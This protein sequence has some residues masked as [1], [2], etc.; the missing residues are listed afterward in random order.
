ML[1]TL[2]KKQ[3]TEIFR[4]YFINRKTGKARSKGGTVGF[5]MFFAM[6]MLFLGLIFFFIAAM[7]GAP[8]I[9][10]GLSWFYFSVMGIVAV[11]FGAFGSI[12]STYSMLYKAK[13]NEFLLS[14]PIP[15]LKILAS[16]MTFVFAMSLLYSAVVWVPTLIFAHISSPFSA[17]AVIYGILLLFVIALFVTVITCALGWVV[18]LISTKI[19][20]KSSVTVIISIVVFAGYYFLS[21]NFSSFLQTIASNADTLSGKMQTYG[22][23]FYHIGCAAAGNGISMLIFTL[24]TLLLLAICLFILTKS[25]MAIVTKSSPIS[26]AKSKKTASL[27]LRSSKSALFRRELKRFTSSSTYMLNCGL[28]M[29][30]LPLIAVFAAIKG[31]ILSMLSELFSKEMP[32]VSSFIPLA[33][34]LVVGMVMSI[35]SISTPSVSLEGKHLWI[36]R[37]M[38]VSGADVLSAKRKLHIVL[39]CVPSIISAIIFCICLRVDIVSSLL[40][41]I[42]IFMFISL[43]ASFGIMLGVKMPDFT[44]TTEAKPIKQSLNVL[45]SMFSGWGV[46]IVAFAGYFLFMS[47]LDVRIYLA[48]VTVIISAASIFMKHR[49]KTVGGALFDAL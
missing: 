46:A 43:T 6:I 38:P 25:F 18:A 30:I 20:S 34:I 35:N 27:K 44:W 13:D 8:I 4:S 22:N 49:V 1:K 26:K 29:L 36:L 12:F 7:L 3:F 15:P 40:A 2:I 33:I 10:A 17:A 47:F 48:C 24:C 41:L 16:R 39:N 14:L 5:F 28:G 19:K 21:R 42:F 11:I 37:T 23:L 45:L 32:V 31:D 9:S